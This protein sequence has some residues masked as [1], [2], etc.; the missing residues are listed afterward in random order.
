MRS[1]YPAGGLPRV[2]RV[3]QQCSVAAIYLVRHGE[4][5]T[6]V[7]RLLSHRRAD[8][9]LTE[10]GLRQARLVAGRIAQLRPVHIFSSPLRR[11][12]QT[13]DCIAEVTCAPITEV[14]A[15]REIDYGVMDGRGDD[16][17]RTI[18]REVY[19]RW[20]D[21]EWG[22]RFPGGE[23]LRE[24]CDR[25]TGVLTEV[26]EIFPR[27]DVAVVAHGG[28]FWFVVPR[29]CTVPGDRPTELLNTSMTVLRHHERAVSCELWGCVVH[30]DGDGLS[31]P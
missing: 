2:P 30:L 26:M 12:R 28:L 22:A 1:I 16:E 18:T 6:N 15:L 25:L 5:E 8:L 31:D 7:S 21:G 23:S 17:A 9:P 24:L 27:D 20:K 14:D 3:V 29:L 13:D 10:L 19:R 4:S 11:A